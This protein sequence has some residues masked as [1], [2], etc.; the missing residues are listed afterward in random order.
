M[1][2]TEYRQ[3]AATL[4]T[5]GNCLSQIRSSD[6]IA[7]E[8]VINRQKSVNDLNSSSQVGYPLILNHRKSV[9]DSNKHHKSHHKKLKMKKNFNFF[10]DKKTKTSNNDLHSASSAY[11]QPGHTLDRIINL[12]AEEKRKW[13]LEKEEFDRRTREH[14]RHLLEIEQREVERREEEVRKRN[15]E[16]SDKRRKNRL[17]QDKM[18]EQIKTLEQKL[19]EFKVAHKKEEEDLEDNIKI[20]ED[21]L[22]EVK[23]DMDKRM[24][25]L[26]ISFEQASGNGDFCGNPNVDAD[27]GSKRSSLSPSEITSSTMPL[28]SAPLYGSP[29]LDDVDG[30]GGEKYSSM[31][32]AIPVMTKSYETSRVLQVGTAAGGGG[33]MEPVPPPRNLV[34]SSIGSSPKSNHSSDRS[35]TPKTQ[36]QTESDVDVFGSVSSV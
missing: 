9:E 3:R 17:V 20:M 19:L 36:G 35:D 11:S 16:L 25:N 18:Q 30:G 21:Q 28:P 34:Q 15:D 22:F 26:D 7:A 32:P 27:C 14:E 12:K 4:A 6:Y 33:G 2:S 24:R 1:S 29:G 13:E 23:S 5:A 31:Y 10:K 8:Y